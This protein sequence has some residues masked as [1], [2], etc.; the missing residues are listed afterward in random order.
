[1]GEGFVVLV[2]VW[3]AVFVVGAGLLVVACTR[4]GMVKIEGIFEFPPIIDLVVLRL[5]LSL[6]A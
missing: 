4:K 2:G 5:L 1:M 3:S 6:K